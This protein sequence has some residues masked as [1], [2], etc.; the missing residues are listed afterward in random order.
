MCLCKEGRGGDGDAIAVQDK[1]AP[2]LCRLHGKMLCKVTVIMYVSKNRR[3][4]FSY[5]S[6]YVFSSIY[7]KWSLSCMLGNNWGMHLTLATQRWLQHSAED[8]PMPGV[9]SPPL[10]RCLR[11]RHQTFQVRVA[12]SG[13][14]WGAFFISLGIAFD[15]ITSQL[16]LTSSDKGLLTVE[17]TLIQLTVLPLIMAPISGTL[18]HR[19]Y[20]LVCY[21]S[22][23][24]SKINF[25]LIFFCRLLVRLTCQSHYYNYLFD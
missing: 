25:R 20:S 24:L 5:W 21:D 11:A 16:S 2:C 10:L 1:A 9:C 19:K 12:L 23:F 3:W 15:P 6:Y 8:R 7:N 4:P 22:G 13:D 14:R 17:S 18:Y